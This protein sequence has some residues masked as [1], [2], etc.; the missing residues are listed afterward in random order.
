MSIDNAE[1][2]SEYTNLQYTESASVSQGH[3]GFKFFLKPAL[4]PNMERQQHFDWQT[5][6]I[7]QLNQ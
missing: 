2:G 6:K 7:H 4:P 1:A 5:E 3:E